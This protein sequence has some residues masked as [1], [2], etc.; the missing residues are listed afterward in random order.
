MT[1]KHLLDI[2]PLDRHGRELACLLDG[3]P[4]HWQARCTGCAW[5]GERAPNDDNLANLI[6]APEAVLTAAQAA[7]AAA[8]ASAQQR[9]A[10]AM[11]VARC[12]GFTESHWA[13][14]RLPVMAGAP[15]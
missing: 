14:A 1:I 6:D 15:H 13:T 4:T 2:V 8:H 7:H 3:P 12:H 10:P 9:H 11:L 5:V